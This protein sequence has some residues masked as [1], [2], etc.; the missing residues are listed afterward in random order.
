MFLFVQ[1]SLLRQ[2]GMAEADQKTHMGVLEDRTCTS[3]K[4]C[5]MQLG[6]LGR[7]DDWCMKATTRSLIVGGQGCRVIGAG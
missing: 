5:K 7:V 1:C 6:A 4:C 2:L 3:S